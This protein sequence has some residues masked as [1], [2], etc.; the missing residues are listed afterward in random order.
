[1]NEH[2][3]R[4]A[5][6]SFLAAISRGTAAQKTLTGHKREEAETEAIATMISEGVGL[7][8]QLLVDINRAATALETIAEN[9]N[10][11]AES[12]SNISELQLQVVRQR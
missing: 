2:E 1:M 12:L 3:I 10:R 11:I 8:T 7:V 5:A 9:S 4:G 6:L